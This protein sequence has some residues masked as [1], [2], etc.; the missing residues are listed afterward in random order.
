MRVL[1][2][3]PQAQA[4]HSIRRLEELGHTA[5]TA[6]MLAIEP[7]G[8]EPPD[9][10]PAALILTSAN[11]VPA[12]MAWHGRF[13]R[14]PVFAVGPRTARALQEGGFDRVISSAEGDGLGLARL[15]SGQV[16][17]GATLLH[18][19]GRDRHTEPDRS[20]E[21]AGYAVTTW[22]VYAAEAAET[23]PEPVIAGLDAGE[24]DAVLHYS[25]RSAETLVTL[26]QTYGLSEALL[27]A[28]QICISAEAARGLSELGP[29]RIAI[30]NEP[31]EDAIFEALEGLAAD[32]ASRRAR[33]PARPNARQG[34]IPTIP[35]LRN[36]KNDRPR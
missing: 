12:A 29:A 17:A 24:V 3:R 36:V 6:P 35:P 2:T 10:D 31:T 14:L 4:R 27:G 15:I 21:A 34:T 1:V 7:T 9:V 25:R 32:A 8:T 23:L 20:L 28:A 11:A 33:A 18:L 13:G 22:E 26:A 5:L 30:A 19:A 16:R